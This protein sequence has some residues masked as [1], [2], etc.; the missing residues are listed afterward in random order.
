MSRLLIYGLIALAVIGS[1]AGLYVKVHSDGVR[2]G[3]ATIQ[4][5]WDATNRKAQEVADALRHQREAAGRETYAALQKS[6]GKA[7]DYENRWRSARTASRNVPLAVCPTLPQNSPAGTV[8]TPDSGIG[9]RLT[10]QFLRDY[11]TA[12]TGPDGEPVFR[13]PPRP[14]E[15]EL[16]AGSPV[17]LDA[18]LENHAENAN[19]C[20]A[21][22]RQLNKLTTL[23]KRLQQAR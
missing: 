10:Y 1:V 18:V 8:A 19:R 12:W 5:R 11:D 17:A 22:A 13:D 20:S 16:A 23:I 15:A 21:N 9:L 6:Q 3:E 2:E 4:T 14:P 7:A